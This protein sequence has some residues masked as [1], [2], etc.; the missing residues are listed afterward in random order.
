V[1]VNDLASFF[2]LVPEK[3]LS[4]LQ[5]VKLRVA[6]DHDLIQNPNPPPGRGCLGTSLGEHVNFESKYTEYGTQATCSTCREYIKKSKWTYQQH[7]NSGCTST[8][9]TPSKALDI[10]PIKRM[11]DDITL[12]MLKKYTFKKH[13]HILEM[14]D[15]KLKCDLT[16]LQHRFAP[17][18]SKIIKPPYDRYTFPLPSQDQ[19]PHIFLT[20]TRVSSGKLKRK[21]LDAN[22][23][24][25]Y[26]IA[27]DFVLK[28]NPNAAVYKGSRF[29]KSGKSTSSI[30]GNYYS[31]ATGKDYHTFGELAEILKSIPSYVR[32]VLCLQCKTSHRSLHNSS[33]Y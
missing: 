11:P 5:Y 12:Q 16:F 25:R 30:I 26:K 18:K 6:K 28:T 2:H 13:K 4:V 24:Y 9:Y 8:T 21:N 23:D 31:N 14:S 33:L 7:R 22:H 17:G 27:S 20:I 3:M 19:D 29:H 15:M 10:I 1:A 32:V